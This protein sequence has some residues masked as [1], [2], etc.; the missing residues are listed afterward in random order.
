MLVNE[1]EQQYRQYVKT[2]ANTHGKTFEEAAGTAECEEY[3][4]YCEE[5]YGRRIPREASWKK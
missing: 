2:F 1:A 5:V 4:K 3:R